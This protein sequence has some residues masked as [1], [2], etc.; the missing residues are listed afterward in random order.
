MAA[1]PTVQLEVGTSLVGSGVGK[2]QAAGSHKLSGKKWKVRNNLQQTSTAPFM[3][4]RDL[5][6]CLY[7]SLNRDKKSTTIL[8]RYVPRGLRRH[9]QSQ[10]S[11]TT[12]MKY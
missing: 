12:R 5:R 10:R 1:G 9:S 3:T 7:H 6:L 4:T 11:D 8:G 2:R